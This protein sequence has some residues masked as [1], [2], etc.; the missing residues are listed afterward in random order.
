MK[1]AIGLIYSST[2]RCATVPPIKVPI[3]ATGMK[4]VLER[5]NISRHPP[6]LPSDNAGSGRV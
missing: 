2:P 1:V 4:Y 6:H 3:A 5:L